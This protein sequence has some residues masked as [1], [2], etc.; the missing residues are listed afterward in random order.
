N[1]TLP[2]DSQGY[3]MPDLEMAFDDTARYLVDESVIFDNSGDTWTFNGAVADP[4]R[5]VRIVMAYTDA[6]GA[7]GTS[8]Q[9]N[10]LNLAATVGATTYLG[11]VFSGQNSV[12]GGSP[13][14]ANNY[15]AVFLP[16]G[17]SGAISVT[18]TG[19]NIAGD[20]VPNHG[21]GT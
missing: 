16:A 15:E 5:P 20:G 21:D 12:P 18:V 14:A 10:D 3:G 1:D 9:V 4:S 19:F 13:D 7:V 17:T 11:N 8:P 6:P 2:S